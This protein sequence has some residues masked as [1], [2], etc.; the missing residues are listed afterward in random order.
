M[1][2]FFKRPPVDKVIRQVR[3]LVRKTQNGSP[4]VMKNPNVKL[5]YSLHATL[6]ESECVT[7]AEY[8]RSAAGGHWHGATVQPLQNGKGT[9]VLLTRY[10]PFTATLPEIIHES[11]RIAEAA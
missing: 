7:V 10:K 9:S 11:I 5:F 4:G 1:T 3:S 6:T 8:F 2:L